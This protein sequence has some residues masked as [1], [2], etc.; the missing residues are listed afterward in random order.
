MISLKK[1]TSVS[2][3]LLIAVLVSII[4]YQAGANRAVAPV[5]PATVAIVNL[6]RV[7]NGL[8]QRSTA[9]MQ[10]RSMVSEINAERETR[11]AE[12]QRLRSEHTQLRRQARE[13]PETTADA[14]AAEEHLV[15][16]ELRFRAWMQFNNDYVD[17]EHSLVLQDL[18]RVVKNAAAEMARAEGYDLVLVDDAEGELTVNPESRVPRTTQVEQQMFARQMLYV[19]PT[20]DITDDLIERMN[21]A[22]RAGAAAR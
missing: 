21:N 20:I 3:G 13:N 9:E 19:S 14:D 15:L 10:V 7:L 22:Y 2:S 17:I 16:E 4:A 8:E 1:H 5:Q 12:L 6:P 11:E 18:Y